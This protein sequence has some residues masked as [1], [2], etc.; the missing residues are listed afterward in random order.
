MKWSPDKGF[1]FECLELPTGKYLLA[2][3]NGNFLNWKVVEIGKD[4]DVVDVQLVVDHENTGTVHVNISKGKGDYE[5]TLAPINNDGRPLIPGLAP[6][7]SYHIRVATKIKQSKTATLEG[8]RPGRYH[9]RLR[10]VK[11]LD[12]GRVRHR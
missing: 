11:Q 8:T 1:T 2:V 5:V 10:S 6:G 4:D 9:V 12:S 3:K 7:G